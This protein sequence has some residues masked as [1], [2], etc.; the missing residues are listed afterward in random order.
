MSTDVLVDG[1]HFSDTTTS[2]Q[3]VGWRAVAANLSDLAASGAVSVEGISVG[4]IAPG[5]TSWSWVEA[6]YQGISEA[7]TRF[8][9]SLLGGD[10]S[11]GDQ[12]ILA[13]TALGRLGPL[14]LLRS[15]ARPGDWL[16]VS[17]PHGLSRLG[18]A[19]LQAEKQE[20]TAQVPL[21]LRKQAINAHQR[22][23]PRLDGIS[24]LIKC[25]PQGMPWR[26]GGTDSSDGLLTALQGLCTASGCKALLK[27]TTLPRAPGWPK[28]P[29]WDHWCLN[30]G[31]DFELV[32]SLPECWARPWL[33]QIQGSCQIGVMQAGDARVYWDN[34]LEIRANQSSF[35]HFSKT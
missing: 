27:S 22:P 25:K 14:P 2:G 28:G 32:L 11:K 7:L 13:I 12:K 18:L 35:E 1:V 16:I 3:D 8:G 6:V 9:G 30:G 20:F 15:E 10:C 5:S 19:L 23:N 24:A 33:E 29:R 17:G 34:G 31:E 4:L 21:I 26:A